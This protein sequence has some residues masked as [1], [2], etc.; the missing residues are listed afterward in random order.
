M[1]RRSICKEKKKK[2]NNRGILPI[3]KS[4]GKTLARWK[5]Y[6]QPAN[7][8]REIVLRFFL[9]LPFLLFRS[10]PNHPEGVA[11]EMRCEIFNPVPSSSP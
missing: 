2:K 5:I 7:L 6:I 1:T 9:L 11:A 10:N 4:G 3:M 8:S